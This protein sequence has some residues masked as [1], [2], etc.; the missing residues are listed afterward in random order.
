M[1][2][3][4]INS[5]GYVQKIGNQAV[6]IRT[7]NPDNSNHARTYLNQDIALGAELLPVV[8]TSGFMV[9]QFIILG[10]QG[11][12]TT[13][14]TR[15][16]G[17]NPDVSLSVT[18]T[19]NTHASGE[20]IQM[21]EF[22]KIEI[23]R[24]NYEQD[25]YVIIA[26]LNIDV[27][28]PQNIT[29]YYDTTGDQYK[30]YQVSF[31]NDYTQNR[32]FSSVFQGGLHEWATISDVRMQSDFSNETGYPDEKIKYALQQAYNSIVIDG[33]AWRRGDIMNKQTACDNGE[34]RYYFNQKF[35]ADGNKD[36]VVDINDLTVWEF[37]CS[38]DY[39]ITDQVLILNVLKGYIV[40]K[41]G[42]PTN[43]RSIKADYYFA[44]RPH[45][46][47]AG[48]LKE[49]S[50]ASAISRMMTQEQQLITKKGVTSY[51]TDGVSVSKSIGD[52]RQVID[53]WSSRYK[54]YIWQIKPLYVR[55][56]K[57]GGYEQPYATWTRF[58]GW[59]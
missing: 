21:T 30:W 32:V 17:I 18:P 20:L 29:Q 47:I 1:V 28:N 7:P 26:T 54:R 44:K 15:I 49:A 55:G 31:Y 53:D 39:D 58:R 37:D 16:T 11:A 27:R 2:Q 51:S 45:A 50:V 10:S 43:N 4:T 38:T 6:E 19:E 41:D 57:V 8:D 34:T 33:F 25:N 48:Y 24:G 56:V 12:V 40:L 13:E 35:I 42:Y 9:G 3:V 22:N 59:Y 14:I 23:W 52:Y 46:E 36:G 5:N